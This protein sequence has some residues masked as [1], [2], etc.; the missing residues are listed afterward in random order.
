MNFFAIAHGILNEILE[1]I[2]NPEAE[3]IV[4]TEEHQRHQ[5]GDKALVFQ[6]QADLCHHPAQQA[7]EHQNQH[8]NGRQQKNTAQYTAQAEF[9]A[10]PIDEDG[11]QHHNAGIHEAHQVDAQQPGGDDAACGNGQGQ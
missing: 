9:A 1:N 6:L 4:H 3:D 10:N 5:Y 7:G 8:G 11:G 2:L